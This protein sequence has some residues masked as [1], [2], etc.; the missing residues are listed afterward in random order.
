[1]DRNALALLFACLTSACASGPLPVSV[2]FE[3]GWTH[4]LDTLT[5]DE[6]AV[7]RRAALQTLES[8]YAGFNV[9]LRNDASGARLIRVEETPYRS[10]GTTS[11]VHPG[12]VGMTYPMATVSS[13]YPDAL[14]R[15]EL[16]ATGC[17]AFTGCDAK[18]RAQLLEGL[19]RGIGATAA[20]ELGH[21]AGLGFSR[22]AACDDCYDSARADTIA[23]FFGVKRW[24]PAALAIMGRLLPRSP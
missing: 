12:S 23:H 10:Y 11:P 21:Q 1:V 4:G 3:N 7:V 20:H 15:D 24:S 19:G 9:Q 17:G 22:D 18:T 2:V 5:G 13:V 8:A 16:A 6:Q 14:Y